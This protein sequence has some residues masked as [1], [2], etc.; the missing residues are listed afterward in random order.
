MTVEWEAFIDAGTTDYLAQVV[1]TNSN[2]L[3]NGY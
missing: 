2:D 3:A 1:L